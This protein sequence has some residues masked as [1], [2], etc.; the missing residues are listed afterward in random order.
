MK[1]IFCVKCQKKHTSVWGWTYKKWNTE[2]G[3]IEGWGCNKHPTKGHE[4][5]TDA[6]KEGRRKYR[7]ELT[8]SFRGGE[9]SKEYVD[10]YPEQAKG[11]VKSGVV[12]QKQVDKAKNVWG[13]DNV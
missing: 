10:Y 4:W 7:K 9:L 13:N 11:M 3:I 1:L 5:T 8:Q 12:T 6:I 2:N